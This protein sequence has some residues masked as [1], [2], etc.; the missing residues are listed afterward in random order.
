[1]EGMCTIQYETAPMANDS[2]LLQVLY[3]PLLG[4]EALQLYQLF[5][6]LSNPSRQYAFNDLLLFSNLGEGRFVQ[7]KKRLEQY[8]LLRSFVSANG[9]RSLIV[10]KNPLQAPD[11]FKDPTLSRLLYQQLDEEAFV[12]RTTFF[13]REDP[14]KGMNEVTASL[15][16]ESALKAWGEEQDI[17]MKRNIPNTVLRPASG[18]DW[19]KFFFGQRKTLP[20]RIRTQENL[21]NIAHLA[22][23]YA[24]DEVQMRKYVNRSM[25]D[26]RT[27]IDFDFLE[28]LCVSASK[29][30]PVDKKDPM[31][32]SPLQ[33]LEYISPKGVRIMADEKKLLK[34][35][36]EN[37][38]FDD[39]TINELTRYCLKQT[40]NSLVP[41][42]VLKV[43]NTWKRNGVDSRS[44]AQAQIQKDQA[45]RNQSAKGWKPDALPEWWN[46]DPNEGLDDDV[47]KQA[48]ERQRQ[49]RLKREQKEAAKNGTDSK[50]V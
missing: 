14:S 48:L 38:G 9:A 37:Y 17:S 21:D 6:V 8:R 35:L 43:A 18:F 2:L 50:P 39:Q 31:D 19:N 44:K 22:H 41:N 25:R 42:F 49:N 34:D 27:W 3:A 15:D 20:D 32:A 4:P 30:K 5:S 45:S 26:E 11:F 12:L 46:K 28:K 29:I 10:L 36:A 1:M 33:Y 24:L 47:I 13:G 7:A 40:N 16:R 23:V